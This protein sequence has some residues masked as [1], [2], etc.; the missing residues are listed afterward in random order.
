M[1]IAHSPHI[2]IICYQTEKSTRRI[3]I[4][5]I[6]REACGSGSGSGSNKHPA[7][8]KLNNCVLSNRKTIYA[9]AGRYFRDCEG[10]DI[11]ERGRE[12]SWSPIYCDHVGDRGRGVAH[13]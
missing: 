9:D 2:K 1:G 4:F 3:D 10:V 13:G 7:W 12:A 5:E 11:F 6:V 8:L